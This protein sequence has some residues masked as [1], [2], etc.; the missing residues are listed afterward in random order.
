MNLMSA[1]AR[2]IMLVTGQFSSKAAKEAEKYRQG[3]CARLVQG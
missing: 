2:R 3:E 1:P